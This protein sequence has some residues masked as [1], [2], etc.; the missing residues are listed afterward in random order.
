MRRRCA[1]LTRRCS[2]SSIWAVRSARTGTA[3]SAAPVG[4]GARRSDAKSMRVVSVSCPTAEM[5]GIVL[6]AVARTTFSSLKA[7]RS[8]SEP[9]PRAIMSRSGRGNVDPSI[10][11][12][13]LIAF[14]IWF[15]AP[16][17]WTSTGQTMTWL[18]MRSARRW[19]MSRITAPVGEVTTPMVL[20]RKGSGFFRSSA[21]N[22]SSASFLRRSSSILRSAPSPASSMDSMMSWYFELLG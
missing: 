12:K 16:S 7:M 10:A 22:P 14:V 11:L 6:S 9:P 18:G 21:N 4:V 17:P 1:P 2:L 5:I 15:A 8:S 20:G 3:F 19:R 13:P